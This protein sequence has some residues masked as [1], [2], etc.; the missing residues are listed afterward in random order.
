MNLFILHTNPILA[1]QYQCTAHKRKMGSEACNML[2]WPLKRLGLK[3]PDTQKGD[4]VRLSHENHPATKWI[5]NSEENYHWAV[6]HA[7]EL[8]EEYARLYKRRHYADVYMDFIIT[9]LNKIKFGSV[10]QIP[11]ARCFGDF[12]ENLIGVRDPVDAYRQFYWLDKE[13]FA[14]WEHLYAI[15]DFWPKDQKY[16]DKAFKDG[17]YTKR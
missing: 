5:N 8:L 13:K 14:R 2:M 10:Y 12:S 9:N 1:A 3:L 6:I 17:I 11:F 16:I 7:K 15:P 4:E